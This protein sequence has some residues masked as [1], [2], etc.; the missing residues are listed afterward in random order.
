MADSLPLRDWRVDSGREP[1]VRIGVILAEDAT[2]ATSLKLPDLEYTLAP[3]DGAAQS[4]KAV[5]ISARASDDAVALNIN[6]QPPIAS[7]QWTLAPK[8]APPP[9]R[10]GGVLVRDIVAGRGFHWQ[11]HVDQ[12][13]AGTI[14][15]RSSPRG[16]VLINELPLEAYL[17]GVITAEMSSRCPIEFLKAQCI[18]ARSWLLANTEAKHRGQAIDRCNDDCCQRYQGTGDLSDVAIEAVQST[19]GVVLFA[20]ERVVDANYSKSCGGIVE[21]PEHVWHARKPGLG[22]AVD[23]PDASA[24]KRFMPVTDANLDDYLNGEW[25]RDT[26]VY[27]SSHVVPEDQL[28]QYLGRVDVSGQYFR[29]T[30]RYPHDELLDIL[31][32]KLADAG[33]ITRLMDLRVTRRGVSG[34]AT[35]MVLRIVGGDGNERDITVRDQYKIRLV[36]HPSFLFSSAFAVKIE[37]EPDGKCK[38]VTLRGAGW[39]HGAGLCQIGA[40]GMAIC[41]IGHE[42]I[43]KHY[44]PG[45]ELKTVYS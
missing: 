14:E 10:G 4:L 36:L 30:V 35:E 44:F 7:K 12:T 28:T 45:A 38:A 37:R 1:L 2:P 5:T 22:P 26:D 13:L 39:G 20:E 15:L 17:A 29:W 11:K 31:R 42:Q 6:N 23:A 25:L 34:R 33:D 21:L 18:T 19:R 16:I 8:V 3:V 24:V 43:V 27:C 32:R 41:K 40:L 9:T